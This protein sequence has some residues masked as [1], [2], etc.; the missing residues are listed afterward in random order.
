MKKFLFNLNPFAVLL[1]PVLFALIMGVSYQFEQAKDQAENN[2]AS[3]P[4][5]SLFY[6]GVT[7]VKAVCSLSKDNVW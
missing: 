6:K 1:I 2:F 5:T 3:T 4:T 7:L